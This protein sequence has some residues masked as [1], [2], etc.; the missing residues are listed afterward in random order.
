[1]TNGKVRQVS[2][3]DDVDGQVMIRYATRKLDQHVISNM[4]IQRQS[5]CCHGVG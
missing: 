1:M 5:F 3:C 4:Y 2:E